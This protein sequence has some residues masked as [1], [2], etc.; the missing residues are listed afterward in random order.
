MATCATA[1][2]STSMSRVMLPALRAAPCASSA[3]WIR[4]SD[5]EDEEAP[6]PAT[7]AGLLRPKAVAA[8]ASLPLGRSSVSVAA[9]KPCGPAACKARTRRRSRVSTK[10]MAA[11]SS[12]SKGRLVAGAAGQS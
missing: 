3:T 1:A 10:G 7:T 12:C 11:K 4:C 2:V 9:T 5:D 6:A 8:E